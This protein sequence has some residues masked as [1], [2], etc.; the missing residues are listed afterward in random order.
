[1]FQLDFAG[2]AVLGLHGLGDF[3]E[4]AYGSLVV[5]NGNVPYV[6]SPE[7]N[8][9]VHRTAGQFVLDLGLEVVFQVSEVLGNFA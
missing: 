5:A 2:N 1:M 9:K 3:N 6:T 4:L 8:G 7:G